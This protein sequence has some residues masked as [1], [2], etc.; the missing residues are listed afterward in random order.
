M[1]EKTDGIH[2]LLRFPWIYETFQ[3]LMGAEKNLQRFVAQE[4][5]PTPGMRILDI[6]CGTG[7]LANYLGDVTYIGFEPNASYVAQGMREQAHRDVTLHAGYFDEQSA[8]GVEPVDLAIVLAV[9]HHMSDEQAAELFRLLARIMKPGGR[10]VTLDNVYV[11]GQGMFERWIIG[12]DRGQ[13]VRTPDTYSA[14]PTAS[15][16]K[17]VGH[18]AKNPRI[19]YTYWIMTCSQPKAA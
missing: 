12:M 11:A 14:L 4:L 7:R 16:D 10:V 13:N 5:R 2:R 6:G 15:F 19:P 3:S 8:A 17:V 9:L 1:S 18:T